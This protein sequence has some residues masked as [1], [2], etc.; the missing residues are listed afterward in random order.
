VINGFLPLNV[1]ARDIPT[2]SVFSSDLA[3]FYWRD[4]FEARLTRTELSMHE[5]Y[6]GIFVPPPRW[7]KLLLIIRTKA[8]S[9]F[10]IKGPT[11][12]QLE[13]VE[14][15][16]SYAVGDKIGL[17]TLF[18]QDEDEITTGGDDK[19]LEFRVS[20]MKVNEGGA[21]KVVLTTLVNPHNLWGKVYLFLIMPFH[22]LAVRTLMA[23]A[24]MANRV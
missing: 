17:F 5:L 16:E 6:L 7:L 19:H 12:K 22:K 4:A 9:V 13:S 8:V 21:D 18:S 23:N 10:G 1:R 3:K 20:V 2:G 15:K 24:V 11:A 14:R